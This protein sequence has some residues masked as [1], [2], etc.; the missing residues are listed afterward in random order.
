MRRTA[1]AVAALA[2]LSAPPAQAAEPADFAAFLGSVGLHQAAVGELQRLE[3]KGEP[4]WLAPGA[5]FELVLALIAARQ[6]AAAAEALDAVLAASDEADPEAHALLEALVLE[7]NG[8]HI[9][10]VSRL[11]RAEAFAEQPQQRRRAARLRCALHLRASDVEASVEC[12]PRWLAAPKRREP[13]ARMQRSA[14]AGWWRGGILSAVVPGLGQAVAGEGLDAAAALA[15]NGSLFYAT[16]DLYAQ[17]FALDGT[18]L[19]IGMTSRYY[20]GNVQHGARAGEAAVR[21][22]QAQAAAELLNAVAALP[23]DASPLTP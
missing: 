5:G 9:A 1:A 16:F 15:V 20:F 18:L 10:A 6:P 2:A 4:A 23:D 14:N 8:Q 22:D 21:R 19:A 17:G 13:L 12:V 7:S 11:G 3:A